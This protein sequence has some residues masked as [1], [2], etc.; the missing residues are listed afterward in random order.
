MDVYSLAL[1]SDENRREG[2]K[3]LQQT[4]I[5][6][7]ISSRNNEKRI[8]RTL[9]GLF[10]QNRR[11]FEIIICDDNST[12]RTAAILDYYPELRRVRMAASVS[13]HNPGEV[14][15]RA[16]PEC[17][18]DIVVFNHADA[19]PLD[20]DYLTCLLK[21]FDDRSVSAVF[22]CQECCPEAPFGVW[23]DTLRNFSGDKPKF[24]LAA[25]A[26]RRELLDEFPFHTGLPLAVSEEWSK[27][28]EAAGRGIAF[29]PSARVEYSR[30]LTWSNLWDWN[31]LLGKCRAIAFG[32]LFPFR[33]FLRKF[34]SDAKS[35]F[36]AARS[37]HR[38]SALP[39]IIPWRL[40][41]H[42]AYYCGNRAARI[43][44][45]NLSC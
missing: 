9:A 18:G 8:G 37:E 35:D 3:E 5:S 41:Q 26:V 23:R 22:A 28:V 11:D 20:A 40:I 10:A 34:A 12:D 15:R 27:R 1:I 25:A 17:R 43:N 44:Q 33:T 19:S 39:G 45:G 13:P 24:S 42:Y 6:I 31:Y 36:G 30:P 29:V 7:V 38:Y 2:R 21:G 14:F 4:M 16:L 32:E